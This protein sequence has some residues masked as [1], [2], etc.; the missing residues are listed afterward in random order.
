ML[1]RRGNRR[2]QLRYDLV[3]ARLRLPRAHIVAITHVVMQL[4]EVCRAHVSGR[5]AISSEGTHRNSE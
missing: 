1:R 3:R 2:H 5:P 4:I